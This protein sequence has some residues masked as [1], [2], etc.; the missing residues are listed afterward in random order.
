MPSLD[1]EIENID[2]QIIELEGRIVQLKKDRVLKIKERK[3]QNRRRALMHDNPT[4]N[5]LIVFL[6]Y[7][8][9]SDKRAIAEF[10]KIDGKELTDIL[11]MARR[12]RGL[13]ENRGTIPQPRWFV[14]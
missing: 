4:I 3:V 10:L 11:T 7:N 13:I 12:N 9:G 2:K 14:K 1:D 6:L 8:P 5:S